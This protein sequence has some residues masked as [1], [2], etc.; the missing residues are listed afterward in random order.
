MASRLLHGRSHEAALNPL[1]KHEEALLLNQVI[2]SLAIM[3]A[4]WVIISAIQSGMAKELR[5]MAPGRPLVIP[6]SLHWPVRAGGGR[7]P[8]SPGRTAVEEWENEGG[9]V[10]RPQ[11]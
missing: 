7:G 11:G 10:R 1:P 5:P 3:G 8:L 2:V 6:G 4:G 9:A